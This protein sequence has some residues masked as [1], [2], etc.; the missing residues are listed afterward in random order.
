MILVVTVTGWGV[1]PMYRFQLPGCKNLPSVEAI[2]EVSH[3]G[4]LHP[5]CNV[6]SKEASLF[7]GSVNKNKDHLE[8]Q[9]GVKKCVLWGV[10]TQKNGKMICH[11]LP[12]PGQFWKKN[13]LEVCQNL[14][15]SFERKKSPIGDGNCHKS[16]E[17]KVPPPNATPPRNKALLKDY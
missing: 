5:P 4:F 1:V 12:N 2:I 3:V 11:L 13:R 9:G 15:S 6:S 7:E 17:S 10:G 14:P 16:W 8:H